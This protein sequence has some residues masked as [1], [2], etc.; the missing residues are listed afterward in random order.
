MRLLFWKQESVSKALVYKMKGL[1]SYQIS[2]EKFTSP[3]L[4]SR[5]T[6]NSPSITKRQAYGAA[7]GTQLAGRQQPKGSVLFLPKQSAARARAKG[8]GSAL[9]SPGWALAGP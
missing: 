5:I 4:A 6:A 8:P 3:V 1:T 2:S 7:N 9:L